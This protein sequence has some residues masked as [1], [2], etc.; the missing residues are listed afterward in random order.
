MTTIIA[1]ALLILLAIAS[2]AHRVTRVHRMVSQ[3]PWLYE[4]SSP[5]SWRTKS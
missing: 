2:F 4:R 1:F 5:L 3:Y